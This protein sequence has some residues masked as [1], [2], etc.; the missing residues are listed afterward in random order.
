MA[1][2]AC[3]GKQ[4]GLNAEFRRHSTRAK[5]DAALEHRTRKHGGVVKGIR[6]GVANRRQFRVWPPNRKRFSTRQTTGLGAGKGRI[7]K[8][9]ESGDLPSD[10]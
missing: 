7:A 4:S 5:A 2:F 8:T 1:A 10:V 6:C 9:R 3:P